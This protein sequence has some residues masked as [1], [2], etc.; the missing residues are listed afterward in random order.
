MKKR[1][2]AFITIIVLLFSNSNAIYAC[3]EN[4]SVTYVTQILFGDRAMSKSSD[5]NVKMLMAA[6]Y[7]CSEQSDNLGQ[8]KIDLLKHKKVPGIP[9]L[10]DINIKSDYLIECSHNSWEHIFTAS[11][12]NQ[13][14]RKMVLQNTVNKVF[15]FG[16]MNNMFGAKK[17]QCNSFAALLYYSHLLADYLA[18]APNE[19]EANV[20]GKM[21][22]AYSGEPYTTVNGNKPSF[23]Y[24]EKKVRESSMEFSNLDSLGRAGV[25]YGCIG[26]DTLKSVGPRANMVGIRPSGWD[27][28]KDHYEGIVNSKPPYVYNRCHLLAHALGGVDEEINLITGTRYLNETGMLPFEN[29][30]RDYIDKTEN[31]VLYRATP[32]YK[33]DNKLASGV[34]LEAYSVE[35]S[36]NGISFNVY[37]YNVQPGV[38]INYANGDN[39]KSDITVGK[40]SIL[41]FAVDNPSDSKPDLIY[42][43]DKH[44]EIV[45]E[46]QKS[47]STYTTMKNKISSIA[48]EARAVGN[49]SKNAAQCYGEMKKYQYKYLEILKSYVPQLLAKEEFFTSTFKR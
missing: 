43:M 18:D 11:K 40:D 30:V 48:S 13:E 41:P 44:F 4:Q 1:L 21:T 35:D 5:E 36:G 12:K 29:M 23:S 15:D 26:V 8:D 47:S 32:V 42:E 2:T 45:F 25:A 24:S 34:Q 10:S 14:K 39:E 33:G 37:C 20:N 19:T 22:A 6:L 27:L 9:K 38:D 17:G 46:K 7:L 49:G 28:N 31:H 3:N 16:T